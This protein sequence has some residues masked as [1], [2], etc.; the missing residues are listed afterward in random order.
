MSNYDDAKRLFEEKASIKRSE[1]GQATSVTLSAGA[2][3]EYFKAN[4]IEDKVLKQLAEVEGKLNTGLYLYAGDVL[5]EDIENAK[6]ASL[7][8]KDCKVSVTVHTPCGPDKHTISAQK[9]F[10]NIHDP[11]K[12]IVRYGHLS[13]RIQRKRTFDNE[14]CQETQD[15]IAAA[16]G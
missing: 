13:S 14:A 9:E 2:R 15:Q 12:N 1:S 5:L 10:R 11:E 4:G 16:L 6:K 3:K 7:D 8:P